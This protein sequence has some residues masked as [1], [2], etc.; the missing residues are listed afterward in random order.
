MKPVSLSL[1]SVNCHPS[2]NRT[3]RKQINS[4]FSRECVLFSILQNRSTGTACHA[5]PGSL[6]NSSELTSR[7][8][9]TIVSRPS[10]P[11]AW[12]GRHFFLLCFGLRPAGM[13]VPLGDHKWI[14]GGFSE[15]WLIHWSGPDGRIS[16]P[17]V[18][19]L[20]VSSTLMGCANLQAQQGSSVLKYM[21]LESASGVLL[22]F[23]YDGPLLVA[24][25]KVRRCEAGLGNL[26][27]W[28][29]K[30]FN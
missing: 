19:L 26:L 30:D 15:R 20:S 14:L 21:R 5:A 6:V 7:S 8:W 18:D 25:S 24:S 27:F 17:K 4:P 9:P 3:N 2:V 16:R 12:S 22:H 29:N 23:E 28:R 13:K 1:F 10:V 11:R